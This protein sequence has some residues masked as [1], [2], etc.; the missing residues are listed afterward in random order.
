[1]NEF[2]WEKTHTTFL[3]QLMMCEGERTSNQNR[4]IE[5]LNVVRETVT[6]GRLFLQVSIEPV[7][8]LL[9]IFHPSLITD[10]LERSRTDLVVTGHDNRSCI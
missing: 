6:R 2:D 1:M 7:Q 8:K 9:E 4:L 10:S 3:S 5:D